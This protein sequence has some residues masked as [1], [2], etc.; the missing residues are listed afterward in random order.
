[1]EKTRGMKKKWWKRR[2]SGGGEEDKGDWRGEV[3]ELRKE[4]N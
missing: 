1:M 2:K 3:R 4:R